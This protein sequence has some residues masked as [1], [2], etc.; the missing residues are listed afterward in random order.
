[1]AFRHISQLSPGFVPVTARASA[2]L[3][4]STKSL[5]A[6][7]SRR[8]SR[9]AS[10]RQAALL[11]SQFS[12]GKGRRVSMCGMSGHGGGEFVSLIRKADGSAYF[13]GVMR[14]GSV[15]H[16]PECSPKISAVRA[17]ELN[18]ALSGARAARMP[19][20]MLTVTFRHGRSDDLASIL[21]ALKV[22][23]E[24]FGQSRGWRGLGLSG[25]VTVTEVTHGNANGWHPHIH[26]LVFGAPGQTEADLLSRLE[27]L[28]SEWVRSGG[29]AG[30]DTSHG[31]AFQVQP[32]SAA[33]DYVSKFGAAEELA[34]GS[35][36]Q[37]RGASSRSPW[38]LLADASEGDKRAGALWAVYAQ[39]FAG[40]RQLVWSKGLKALF[41][42]GEADD[43][44][45]AQEP[46]AA[47]D[48]VLKVWHRASDEWR[49][50][51]RRR[52]GILDAVEAGRCW[53]QAEFG[54]T[55]ADRWRRS[56]AAGGLVE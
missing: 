16:C 51:R 9:A 33:G 19:V 17:S 18:E 36:K 6:A 27:A 22:A 45:A 5:D 20:A 43:E 34:L 10:K 24:R 11:L 29:K 2:R 40:R 39:A 26:R 47:A 1:M 49:A 30:L 48:V 41:G 21:C 50:A 55:D 28:R 13:G 54:P 4:K 15:W 52:S 53:L 35:V 25:H 37:G 12:T 32:A 56:V 23:L 3:V 31:A 46:A 8:L 44:Q 14:C 38:Q 42:I 7:A